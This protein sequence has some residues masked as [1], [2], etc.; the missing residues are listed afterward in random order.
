MNRPFDRLVHL[1]NVVVD[2]VMTVPDLPRRGG[3]LLARTTQVTAGGGFNV[4]AAAARQGLPVL[5]GGRHGTGPFA[6][7]ARAALAA[8]GVT[9]AASP[10]PEADTGVV[11][12]MV[13]PGGE[14]TFV[15][16]PGAETT[17]DAADLARLGVT[18]RDA[19]HLSGY[20][21]LHPAVA[22]ALISWLPTLPTETTVFFDPGPLVDQILP[23][24]L[25]RVLSRVDWFTG[26]AREAGLLTD[27]ET[28][29]AAAARL[30]RRTGRAGVIVR[31]GP[32][33]CVLA[34]RGR[35][36]LPVK[37]FAVAAVDSNGAGDTHTGVFISMIG[38]GLHPAEAARIA[39]A[40]AAISVTRTGPATCPAAAEL[41]AFLAAG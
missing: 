18:A 37:G 39:N 4:I 24:D 3:D 8:E 27:A 22:D 15:T 10:T 38:A 36:P 17:L 6:D 1:G 7:V 26:N 31:T 28:S 9:V 12:V 25:D 13:D 14:R 2:V 20:S 19:V 29:M 11:V 41:A 40:A 32:A 34:V 33:G 35:D 16:G 5:Y 23:L 30:G 21:L